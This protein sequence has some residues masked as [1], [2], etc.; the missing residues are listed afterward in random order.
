MSNTFGIEGWTP[1]DTETVEHGCSAWCTALLWI[2][3]AKVAGKWQLGG[4]ELVLDQQFQVVTGTLDG[5]PIADGKLRGD[6]IA[7]RSSERPNIP[8]ASL[9]IV[10]KDPCVAEALPRP[11]RPR[12]PADAQP[13]RS[14]S[15]RRPSAR[16]RS[17]SRSD[18]E[19]A[20]L[21]RFGEVFAVREVRV[22]VGLEDVDAPS[23]SI[24]RSMRA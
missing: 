10:S 1:D 19:A 14:G 4:G 7:S 12:K 6:Q 2:V 24:R 17:S 9:E 5:K 16:M 8:A 3:P 21:G 13:V 22:R 23:S 20:D 15:H 18:R 11:G